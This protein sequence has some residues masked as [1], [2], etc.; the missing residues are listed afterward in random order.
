MWT[1][2]QNDIWLW[3]MTVKQCL[4]AGSRLLVADR[5][6]IWGN[7]SI[8]KVATFQLPKVAA[9]LVSDWRNSWVS[10]LWHEN[11]CVMEKS[12]ILVNI[13]LFWRKFK[14][15]TWKKVLFE[16]EIKLPLNLNFNWE[17]RS[18][19]KNAEALFLITT[20]N[21]KFYSWFN[22]VGIILPGFIL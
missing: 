5:L 21:Q 4:H 1:T 10:S 16:T 18:R 14:S 8:I 3:T 15:I 7:S 11:S 22:G 17:Q 2:R 9:D 19:P 6:E 13:Y 20:R 12:R